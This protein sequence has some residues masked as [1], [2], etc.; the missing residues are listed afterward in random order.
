[1]ALIEAIR[2]PGTL[3][4]WV[5][6][7]AT[8]F[9]TRRSHSAAI[10]LQNC[11]GGIMQYNEVTNTRRQP[12]NGDATAFDFDFNCFE[13]VVQYNVS[14]ENDGGLLLIMHTARNNLTRYNLCQNDR[15]LL[16]LQCTLDEAN[17]V[18]NNVFY[19]DRGPADIVLTWWGQNRRDGMGAL[20]RNNIFHATGQGRF[21]V[22]YVTGLKD[23]VFQGDRDPASPGTFEGNCY[24][25]PWEG[26]RPQDPKSLVT[27]P[28][29][30]APGTGG[31]GFAAWRGY[32]LQPKSPCRGVGVPI[33]ENGGRDFGGRPLP[34]GKPDLGAW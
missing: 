19:V 12:D 34:H 27:D 1:M 33:P 7:T 17:L 32:Q 18:H 26:A 20:L 25:G 4:G 13:C 24:F 30:V 3:P 8:A 28:L 15:R 9:R 11:V 31:E 14:R 23:G 21:G 16:Y 10:W 2:E 6:A 5:P 29:F 22:L